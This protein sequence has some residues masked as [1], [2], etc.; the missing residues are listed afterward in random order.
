MNPIAVLSLRL[1]ADG[2][3]GQGTVGWRERAACIGQNPE[4]FFPIGSAGPALT[5]AAA[6]KAVCAQCAVRE[7]CLHFALRTGQEYGIWGGLT[8]DE[9]QY[10]RR[11]KGGAAT[12]SATGLAYRAVGRPT[13]NAAGGGR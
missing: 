6:A 12:A 11:R 2:A 13:T 3:Q 9:R 4:L 5:Q 8:E 7:E 10:I 1:A